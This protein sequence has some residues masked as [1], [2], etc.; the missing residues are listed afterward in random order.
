MSGESLNQAPSEPN[1]DKAWED[2]QDSVVKHIDEELLDDQEFIQRK[3]KNRPDFTQ[4][5][6][7]RELETRQA[8]HD[9]AMAELDNYNA[10]LERN[11]NRTE[12]DLIEASFNNSLDINDRTGKERTYSQFDIYPINS[13]K[14]EETGQ[15][16]AE[17][18]REYGD[19]LTRMSELTTLTEV[20]PRF[21]DESKEEYQA[22]IN[23]V[24]DQFHR[25][26]GEELSAY[27]ERIA[28]ASKDGSLL[29]SMAEQM[30]NDPKST[31]IKNMHEYLIDIDQ[32]EKSGKYEP[33][34]IE[35]FRR[36]VATKVIKEQQSRMRQEAKSQKYAELKEKLTAQKATEEQARIEREEAERRRQEEERKRQEE[37]EERARLEQERLNLERTDQELAQKQDELD[38]QMQELSKE[39]AGLNIENKYQN[40]LDEAAQNLPPYRDPNSIV[41]EYAEQELKADNAKSNFIKR[42][43]KGKL[44]RNHYLD[45]YKS[46]I[47]HRERAVHVDGRAMSLGEAIKQNEDR[48]IQ[49]YVLDVAQAYGEYCNQLNLPDLQSI[50]KASPEAAQFMGNLIKEFAT[51]KGNISKLKKEFTE[52]VNDYNKSDLHRSSDGFIDVVTAGNYFDLIIQ[53][54]NHINHELSLSRVIEGFDAWTN[55]INR[56]NSTSF[57][58]RDSIN[59]VLG[60]FKSHANASVVPPETISATSESVNAIITS[61]FAAP[62]AG[63]GETVV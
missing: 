41:Y 62:P 14:D 47:E 53:A 33:K 10:T 19:R 44:F 52:Q 63:Q 35:T 20:I 58:H 42:L 54:R 3:L 57:E 21:E 38:Q 61:F 18:S 49:R 7:T 60:W 43:W 45:R 5:D 4:E 9:Q 8:V 30:V 51:R 23:Q 13:H 6:A 59:R 40:S 12:D 39:M 15:I 17:S 48:A 31:A 26:E 29:V 32:M 46:E 50:E 16:S 28:E 24:G 27:K 36:E 11:Q 1:V 56:M 2:M 55:S 22:R 25:Q 34:Q 37:A